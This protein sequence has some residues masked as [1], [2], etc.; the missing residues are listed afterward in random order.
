MRV[1]L[2]LPDELF[3]RME[4]VRGDVPRSKFVQRALEAALG[5]GGLEPDLA[6]AS[7][8]AVGVENARREFDRFQ[9]A[10]SRAS[11]PADEVEAPRQVSRRPSLADTWGRDV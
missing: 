1:T 7:D 9:G 4:S 10:L 6:A 2:S 8:G 3:G 11:Q 5:D